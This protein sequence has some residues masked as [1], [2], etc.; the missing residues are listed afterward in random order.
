MVRRILEAAGTVLADHGYDGTTT[1]RIASAAGI[2]PGSLYQYFPNKDAVISAIA[3][4]YFSEMEMRLIGHLANHMG[5]ANE[6][7]MVRESLSVTLDAMTSRLELLRIITENPRKFGAGRKTVALE[8]QLDEL[9]S[10]H[11]RLRSQDL[12]S[13]RKIS[14]ILVRV[15]EHACIRYLLDRPPLDREEFLDEIT[16]L[17]V[18][19]VR[20]RGSLDE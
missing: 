7:Q 17:V 1:S 6:R 2:S 15:I 10:A 12:N 4:E 13:L 5:S 19:Y 18:S 9:T 3:D 8:R 14:W 16:V 20:N 11:L